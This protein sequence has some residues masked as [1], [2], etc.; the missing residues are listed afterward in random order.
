MVMVM[1][2]VVVV[3]VV[4]MVMVLHP[5]ST[6]TQARVG[7][8]EANGGGDD[9]EHHVH[10]WPHLLL[11]W[12]GLYVQVNKPPFF[13]TLNYRRLSRICYFEMVFIFRLFDSSVP[14][15]NQLLLGL[16]EVTILHTFI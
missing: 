9:G 11:Q 12:R 16:L 5:F 3:V 7:E 15:W 4:V 1:V 6:F 14:S 8:E 13:P 2:N 10:L